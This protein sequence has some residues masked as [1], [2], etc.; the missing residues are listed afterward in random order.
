MSE[1][2]V[3]SVEGREPGNEPILPTSERAEAP[4]PSP[5]VTCRRQPEK[6]PRQ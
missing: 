2:E 1:I 6:K 3:S 5:F 4:V